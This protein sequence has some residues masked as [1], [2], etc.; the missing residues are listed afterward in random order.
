MEKKEVKGAEVVIDAFEG[1]RT[2]DDIRKTLPNLI[3]VRLGEKI[4]DFRAATSLTAVAEAT[5]RF[6]LVLGPAP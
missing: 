4:R 2:L 1:L 3:P 5:C 6:R